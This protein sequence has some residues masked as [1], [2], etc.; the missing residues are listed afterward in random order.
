MDGVSSPYLSRPQGLLPLRCQKGVL[1]VCTINIDI[2]HTVEAAADFW[3]CHTT[4]PRTQEATLGQIQLL[5]QIVQVAAGDRQTTTPS[6]PEAI[7]G[8]IQLLG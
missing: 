7:L 6:T 1:L 4:T 3:C 8:Q 2:S 5:G